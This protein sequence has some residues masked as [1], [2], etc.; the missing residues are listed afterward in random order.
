MPSQVTLVS[1]DEY[2]HTVYEPDVD[3]VDGVLEDRN[4]GERNHGYTQIMLGFLFCQNAGKWKIYPVTETRVQ[5]TP[6]RFRVP[7]ISV[8]R[9]PRPDEQVFTHPPFL[10]IEI[11]SP[12]DRM[13]RMTSKIADHLAFG[14]E[15]VWVIDPQTRRAFVYQKHVMRE[16]TD[17]VL[18]A[19]NPRIEI[20]LA[21]ILES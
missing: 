21:D 9:L 12:E 19:E 20:P 11:L 4:E 10:C 15:Y 5:V 17:G 3:Y 7:D 6:T 14:V 8:F 13:S 18:W 16:V 1:V 2:L